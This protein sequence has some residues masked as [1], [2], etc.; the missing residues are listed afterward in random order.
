MALTPPSPHP[1]TRKPAPHAGG[2]GGAVPTRARPRPEHGAA[3]MPPPASAPPLPLPSSPNPAPTPTPNQ[4]QTN[5]NPKPNQNQ[6]QST[7]CACRAQSPHTQGGSPI[8][9]ARCN[10]SYAHKAT[11]PHP[12]CCRR[13]S[14]SWTTRRGARA[15]LGPRAWRARHSRGIGRLGVCGG[16]KGMG[17]LGRGPARRPCRCDWYGGV[18]RG[19]ADVRRLRREGVRRTVE[20]LSE[21]GDASQMLGRPV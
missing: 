7:L 15:A 9:H 12:S 2:A 11:P 4:P 21:K 20:L 13:R 16:V 8:A 5:P 10:A 14:R 6:D 3:A 17:V 19:R 1:K 18:V